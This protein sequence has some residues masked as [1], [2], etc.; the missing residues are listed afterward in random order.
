MS[1]LVTKKHLG[2]ELEKRDL[3]L[4]T[5]VGERIKESETKLSK[6]LHEH[7]TVRFKKSKEDRN[8]A[9]SELVEMINALS[10][11][12]KPIAANYQAAGKMGKWV[13]AFLTFITILIVAL[14]NAK[15]GVMQLRD[16]LLK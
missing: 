10:I 13:I 9:H 6:E 11:T 1:E 8:E 15:S 14:A 4:V 5:I 16:I 3:H 7:I 2:D 12:L